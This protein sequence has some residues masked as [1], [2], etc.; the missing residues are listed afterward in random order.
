MNI[1]P[2]KL[3][4][5]DGFG[6]LLSAFLLGIVLVK[7]EQFIGMPRKTLYFLAFLPCVFALYDFV[8]YFRDLKNWRIFLKIIAIANL[9]YC[10]ISLCFVI[11]FWQELTIWGHLYFLGEMIIVVAL[12]V[13]E[14]K[15]ARDGS[16]G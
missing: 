13:F 8:C 9:L 16:V 7:F 12:S 4:L 2:R 1:N 5:L 6:A 10:V 15:V 3:L 14:L 11:A